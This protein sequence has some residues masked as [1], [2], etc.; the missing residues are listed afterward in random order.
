MPIDARPFVAL[1]LGAGCFFLLLQM[2][3]SLGQQVS[4][5]DALDACRECPQCEVSPEPPVILVDEGQCAGEHLQID[6]EAAILSFFRDKKRVYVD[7]HCVMK[8][9]A[10]RRY[11][12]NGCSA[13]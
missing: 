13:T 5:V 9:R 11:R 4:M 3:R 2:A 1:L 12:G 7:L 6:E 10:G 8:E